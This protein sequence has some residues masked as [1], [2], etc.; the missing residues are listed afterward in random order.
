M[1]DTC[2]RCGKHVT[3]WCRGVLCR[4]DGV[5]VVENMTVPDDPSVPDLPPSLQKY[6][7]KEER[8]A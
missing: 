4:A 5:P 7:P 1:R 2:P 8:R 6:Y 3:H